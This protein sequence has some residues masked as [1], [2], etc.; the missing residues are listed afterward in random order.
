VLE[1]AVPLLRRTAGIR[2][3]EPPLLLPPLVQG[4]W[5]SPHRTTDPALGYV[6]AKIGGIAAGLGPSG[7]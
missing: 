6:R 7:S 2:V 3:L 1:R 5:W 4:L